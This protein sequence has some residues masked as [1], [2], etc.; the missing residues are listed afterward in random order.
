MPYPCENFGKP[1]TVECD[2]CGKDID[3]YSED[4][5]VLEESEKFYCDKNCMEEHFNFHLKDHLWLYEY[6]KVMSEI[7]GEYLK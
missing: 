1:E 6:Y 2:Y 4:L 7:V 5:I 3:L